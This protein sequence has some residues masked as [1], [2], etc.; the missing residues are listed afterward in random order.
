MDRIELDQALAAHC[1][2]EILRQE[3]PDLTLVY[4]PHLD[5]RYGFV[6]V[7]GATPR[8]SHESRELRFFPLSELPEGLDPA[9]LRALRKLVL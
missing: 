6:A 3:Q 5:L 2:A 9:L 1:A 7:E 8:V 4:L